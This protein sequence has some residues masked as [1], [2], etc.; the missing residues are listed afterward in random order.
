MLNLKEKVLIGGVVL[1][2]VACV[3]ALCS[4]LNKKMIDS[5][6]EGGHSLEYCEHQVLY[7]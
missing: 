1:A 5:C 7:K 6:V 2:L 3:W 4:G